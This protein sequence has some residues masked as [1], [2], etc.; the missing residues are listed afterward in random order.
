MEKHKIRPYARLLTM[1]GEQLIKNETIA[2][3]ELVKN[4]Y[5]ADASICKVSFINFNEDK[6]NRYDSVIEIEDDGFGMSKDIITNHFLNPATPIKKEGKILRHSKM[7][8]VCQG[9]KGIGRFSMLKLGKKVTVYSKE[10]NSDVVHSICF[11]FE[12]YDDEFLSFNGKMKDIFLDEIEVQYRQLNISDLDDDQ[13]I[14]KKNS[15]TLIKIEQLRGVWDALKIQEFQK[16]MLRFSPFELDNNRVVTNLDFDTEIFVNGEI[17]N[18]KTSA[19]KNIEDIIENKALYKV[20]GSYDEKKKIIQLSYEEANSIE[21]NIKIFLD[22]KIGDEISIAFRGISFYN[23]DVKKFFQNGNNTECGSFSFDFYIFDFDSMQNEFFGLSKDDKELVR[24]HRIFLYR[25]NV[26]VQPYGAPNDD[27]LQIDRSRAKDK[28]GNMFS[29]DQIVGQIRI[30]KQENVNLRDKTSREGIIEDTA[31]FDQLSK[32]VKA[33]LSFIRI[34]LYQ[35]YKAKE[36][37]KK[38]NK[39]LLKEREKRND[40]IKIIREAC[41]DDSKTLKI[42]DELE[43]SFK[44]QERIYTERLN[45]AEQLAGV[46]LSVETASH[47]VMVSLDRLRDSVHQIHISAEPNLV[48]DREKIYSESGN[49]ESLTSLI[50]MK[51]KDIQQIFVSSKQRSRPIKVEEIIKKIES[52]YAKAYYEKGITVKYVRI[53]Q[54][55]VM[56]QTIDAVLFQVFINLFDN[57]LYWLQFNTKEKVVT[58]YLDGNGQRVI[59]ADNGIGILMDDAPYIFEAFYTGKGEEGRGLGLYIAKK[60]LNRYKYDIN[61]LMNEY[62]KKEKGA[63]FVIDFIANDELVGNI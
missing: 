14:V 41:K 42:V 17:D 4:A 51:M 43:N 1:L 60:L 22:E 23:S 59:F 18:Y 21:K 29:N 26:R 13:L 53:G 39:S 16:D 58:I 30:T 48:W 38:K 62:D 37:L 15:G 20:H 12:D 45:V 40:S 63:N 50:Y 46:G 19:L 34:K 32:I 27:W 61:V 33:I 9:E 49:A 52:I 3:A 10:Q 35:N 2:L 54:S 25:D 56:A 47:D 57:A 8:R 6:T 36:E 11:N 44:N 28:A 55:P 5:D 31:A 7:G 24:D